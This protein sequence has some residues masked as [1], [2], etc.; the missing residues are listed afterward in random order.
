MSPGTSAGR[1]KP[2]AGKVVAKSATAK[3][4][5]GKSAGRQQSTKPRANQAR[6]TRKSG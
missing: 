5:T 6:R 2:A 3:P 1:Q 4:G